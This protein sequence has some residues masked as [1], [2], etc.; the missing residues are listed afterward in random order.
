M[1]S[2]QISAPAPRLLPARPG[3]EIQ[4]ALFDMD[5]LLIDSEPHWRAAEME[6]LQ[7]LG[8]PLTE[9]MCYQTMG[10]RLDEVVTYWMDRHPWSGPGISAVA[11]DIIDALIARIRAEG[12]PL[13]GAVQAVEAFLARG[14]PI[15]LATSAPKRIIGPTLEAL[16]LSDAFQVRCSADDDPLGKPHPGVYLRAAGLLDLPARRCMTFEDSINGLISALAAR[17]V[18]VA[19]PAPEAA[20]DPRYSVAAAQLPDLT[21]VDE[22]WLDAWRVRRG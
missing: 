16:G 20:E 18:A 5:G 12:R 17:T 11:D 1:P 7:P 3:P 8:V 4:G 22:G 14:C 6:V 13:P 15:A 19:V 2:P 21:V 9:E 10:L